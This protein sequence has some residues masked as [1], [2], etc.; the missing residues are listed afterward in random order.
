MALLGALDVY[1][2]ATHG[3][4]FLLGSF[5]TLGILLFA[6]PDAP[7]VKRWNVVVGHCL[8]AFIAVAVA[9]VGGYSVASRAVAY[10]IAITGMLLTGAVHPP[11]GALVVIFMENARCQA[12]GWMYVVYPGLAGA[13]LLY[14]CS[15]LCVY[16]RNNVVF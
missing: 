3:L 7:V 2:K 6:A 12:L 4:P 10:G 16:L 13:L 8:A 5:G 1:I 14:A 15:R 9:S 11:G